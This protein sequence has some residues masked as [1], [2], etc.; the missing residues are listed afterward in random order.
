ML[1]SEL[2][3]VG[4]GRQDRST[5]RA[6]RAALFRLPRPAECNG[7][8]AAD[9]GGLGYAPEVADRWA[10]LIGDTPAI[11]GENLVVQDEQGQELARLPLRPF[12]DFC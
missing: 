2:G 5:R 8:S 3:T 9:A 4:P 6:G 12:A 1:P 10:V 11:D 7:V